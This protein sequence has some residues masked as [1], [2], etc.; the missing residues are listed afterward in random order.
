MDDLRAKIIHYARHDDA[1][2]SIV[3]AARQLVLELHTWEARARFISKVAEGV[4]DG[5]A[6]RYTPP[7]EVSKLEAS[8]RYVGCFDAPMRNQLQAHGLREPARSR[9]RKRLWR[10]TVEDCQLACRG[11]GFGLSEGGFSTGNAHA[12]GR[13]LCASRRGPVAAPR[14][15]RLRARPD[16][17]CATTCSLHDPRPCGGPRAMALF[18]PPR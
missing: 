5:H 16:A 10:Y 7:P 12:Q 11:A 3:R 18:E 9:N 2:Q 14:P 4:I 13:C 1:R 8:S 6:P 17:D 15:P